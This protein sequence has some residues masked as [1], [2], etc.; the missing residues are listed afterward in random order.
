[1]FAVVDVVPVGIAVGMIP[2]RGGLADLARASDKRHLPVLCQ[3]LEQQRVV[4]PFPD[5]HC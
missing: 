3:M 1:M 2:A 4:D 5:P